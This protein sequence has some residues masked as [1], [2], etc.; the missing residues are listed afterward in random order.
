[1]V[2]H[3]HWLIRGGCWVRDRLREQRTLVFLVLGG[4]KDPKASGG[5][6]LKKDSDACLAIKGVAA[7]EL[8]DVECHAM[9]NSSKWN[10]GWACQVGRQTAEA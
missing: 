4:K 8:K 5:E 3:W 6:T 9:C 7:P 1:M 2:G 10:V